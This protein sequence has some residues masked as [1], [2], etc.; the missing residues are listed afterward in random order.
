MDKIKITDLEVFANHGVFPEERIL[1]QKFMISALLETDLKKAAVSGQLEDT[2]NYGEVCQ[3]I[4]DYTQDNTYELIETLADALAEEILDR[5]EQVAAVTL[6]VAKPWAPIGLPL[7]NVSVQIT[8]RRHTAY[9]ALGSNMGDKEGYLW[10]A[11]DALNELGNLKVVKV[12]D[13][14]VTKPYG[15]VEQDDFLNGVLEAE[16][17]MEP[18]ELLDAL[19]DIENE[20]GRTREVRWGP[21]TLDLDIIFFDDLVLD[22]EDLVIPHKE[23]HMRDFVLKPLGQIAP[24]KRHPLLGKTVEELIEEL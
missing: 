9:I 22:S 16:T 24:W 7:E 18:R 6:E 23:M 1:G 12:S 15:K 4:S 10:G 17:S 8:R 20:A 3:F 21:R 19:H 13:F 11:V 5:Y 14:I 2:V